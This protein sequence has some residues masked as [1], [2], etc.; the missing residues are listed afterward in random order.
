M[1]VSVLAGYP[2]RYF[3]GDFRELGDGRRSSLWAK[4]SRQIGQRVL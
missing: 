2:A 3:P 4:L 1:K